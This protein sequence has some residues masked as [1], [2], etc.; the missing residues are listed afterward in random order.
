MLV[1]QGLQSQMPLRAR[2]PI[3]MSK[4]GWEPN[5]GRWGLAGPKSWLKDEPR[6]GLL[7]QNTAACD[8]LSPEMSDLGWLLKRRERYAFFF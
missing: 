5:Q 3:D 1:S 6:V 8:T 2:Q 7:K 4:A